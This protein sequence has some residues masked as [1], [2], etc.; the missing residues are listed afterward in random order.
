M[1]K[2]IC[3]AL[4]FTV[5]F[6]QCFVPS[7]FRFLILLCFI[8]V[9]F[10]FSFGHLISSCSF[11]PRSFL[12]LN[13]FLLEMTKRICSVLFYHNSVY[14][15]FYYLIVLFFIV[16]FFLCS[17]LAF[18][19][20]HILCFHVLFYHWTIFYWKWLRESVQHRVHCLVNCE[21]DIT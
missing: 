17:L 9:F 21:T 3:S 12:S 8:I 13:H 20:S 14:L 18:L 15:L 19:F 6:F 2:G 7:L 11:F 4:F 1:N 16:I 5:L 10:M